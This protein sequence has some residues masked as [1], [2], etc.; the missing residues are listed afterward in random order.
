MSYQKVTIFLSPIFHWWFGN[1]LFSLTNNLES[2]LSPL[3]I[4]LRSPGC[5]AHLNWAS[6]APEFAFLHLPWLPLKDPR[7]NGKPRRWRAWPDWRLNALSLVISHHDW[8]LF[9]PGKIILKAQTLWSNKWLLFFF[10]FS[11]QACWALLHSGCRGTSPSHGR[12]PSLLK[13]Y[14]IDFLKVKEK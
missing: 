11:F 10:L 12:K 1:P 13:E 4:M 3:P 6:D 14:F 9:G 5:P 7:A 8:L 2:W